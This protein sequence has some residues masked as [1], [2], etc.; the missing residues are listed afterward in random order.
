M[1]ICDNKG[2]ISVS[3]MSLDI[4]FQYNM[5]CPHLG[6]AR[7][8]INRM[9]RTNLIKLYTKRISINP[10]LPLGRNSAQ[11]RSLLYT[12]TEMISLSNPPP[13]PICPMLL[14]TFLYHLSFIVHVLNLSDSHHFSVSLIRLEISSYPTLI[15]FTLPPGR[16]I[17]NSSFCSI[18][19]RQ[20]FLLPF[21]FLR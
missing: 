5:D 17:I 8:E 18:Q 16:R 12:C 6:I 21:C 1:S 11:R 7:S 2:I 3:G 15:Q 14:L 19:R 9:I 13:P 20:S 10:Y 4:S